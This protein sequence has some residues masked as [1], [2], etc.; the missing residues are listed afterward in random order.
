MRYRI[1]LGA[2]IAVG[3]VYAGCGSGGGGA[4]GTLAAP[5][6]L[7]GTPMGSGVHLAWTD[8]SSGEESFEIERSTGTS[9]FMKV[10]S[11]AFDTTQYH[12]QGLTGGQAYTF[13]VRAAGG[14]SFSPY[15]NNV[16]ATA[17]SG[18]GGGAGGGAGGG[19]GLDGLPDGGYSF[20]TH[21]KPIFVQSCGSGNNSCHSK[22]AY[23]PT[24]AG[25]C[26]GW[27]ALSDEPLGS[28]NPAN[29]A[30]TGCPDL[31]L[32]QRLLQLDTW[33]CSN[34]SRK[35]VVPNDTSASQLFQ[36]IDPNA[37]PSRGG[38]CMVTSTVPLG[39]MPRAPYVI[40]AAD[41]NKIKVWIQQGAPNN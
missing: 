30:D 16:T 7:I 25:G 29:N 20:S 10:A 19:G 9:S 13:R 3:L 1:L 32:Y 12:D 15:S 14:G 38:Q 2:L 27:L 18:S 36:V 31:T 6:N 17:P 23:G 26:L 5:S 4:G 40:S 24:S 11:V 41:L 35:Y 39:R 34:P 22:M 37:D 8:N 28:K 21:I 33:L